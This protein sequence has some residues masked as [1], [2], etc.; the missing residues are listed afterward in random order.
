MPPDSSL[1]LAFILSV[2]P[3]EARSS[4]ARGTVFFFGMSKYLP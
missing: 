2:R 1:I 4:L 3:T